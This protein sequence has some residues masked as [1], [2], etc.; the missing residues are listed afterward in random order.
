M[1]CR[2]NVYNRLLVGSSR[3]IGTL[4]FGWQDSL[5]LYSLA[6]EK[7]EILSHHPRRCRRMIAMQPLQAQRRSTQRTP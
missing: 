6:L 2:T 1:L 5:G 3:D 7:L 4:S